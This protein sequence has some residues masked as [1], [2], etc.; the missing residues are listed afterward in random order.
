MVLGLL[1]ALVLRGVIKGR[2]S[3]IAFGFLPSGALISVGTGVF[4]L[5]GSLIPSQVVNP[6]APDLSSLSQGQE[7][8]ERNCLV[9]HGPLGLGDGP[10][11]ITL[12]PPP[13]NLQDHMV[14]GVHTDGR[15]MEWITDGY[16]DSVMTGFGDVISEKDRW[17]LLNY[18]RTLVPE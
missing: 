17:H 14:V 4:V 10:V 2:L 16:P 1:Y 8:Y 7:I 5:S 18:I 13:A 15:I 12:N 6:I 9:C 3:Q 11:G